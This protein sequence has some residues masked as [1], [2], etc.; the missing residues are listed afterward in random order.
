MS[1]RAVC[2]SAPSPSRES[3]PQALRTR[4]GCWGPGGCAAG[5]R[6]AGAGTS[7]EP[8]LGHSAEVWLL[9]PFSFLY[10]FEFVHFIVKHI[11]I[12]QCM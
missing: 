10:S 11:R 9:V 12:K 3:W 5:L 2:L 4:L 7:P 6:P 1:V 8:F